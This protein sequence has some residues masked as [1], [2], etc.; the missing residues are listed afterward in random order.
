VFYQA[1]II[2]GALYRMNKLTSNL[3]MWEDLSKG[4]R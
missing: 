4:D 1:G 3:N 2:T